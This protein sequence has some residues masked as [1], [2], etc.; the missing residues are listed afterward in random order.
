MLEF[1]TRDKQFYTKK[2]VIQSIVVRSVCW[3]G[4]WKCKREKER[5][6]GCLK[7][8]KLVVLLV[9]S[10]PSILHSVLKQH[11]AAI[12]ML[13]PYT[14]ILQCLPSHTP[15][16]PFKSHSYSQ[17]RIIFLKD[18]H[19]FEFPLFHCPKTYI[20]MFFKSYTNSGGLY[21]K[22]MIDPLM[23]LIRLVLPF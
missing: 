22:S 16:H 20:V 17:K 3:F 10:T 5:R 11:K 13:P 19:F 12:S 2:T 4:F 7:Y 14:I 8:R 21:H 1:N 6:I 9:E 23:D 15:S 18:K